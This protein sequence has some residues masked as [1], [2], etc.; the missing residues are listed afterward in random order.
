MSL[1]GYSS[2]AQNV[3]EDFRSMLRHEDYEPLL[4]R[5]SLR[6]L[7]E[8]AALRKA[9]PVLL[10]RIAT[11]APAQQKK[12][13]DKLPLERRFWAIS[14]AAQIAFEAAAVL[15]AVSRELQPGQAFRAMIGSVQTVL[16]ATYLSPDCLWPWPTI[17][18]KGVLD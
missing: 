18:P 15:D 14:A 6:S 4:A 12:L 13:L 1:S 3:G 2:A 10:E 11:A 9:E 8:L 7:Q 16:D 17:P 5:L